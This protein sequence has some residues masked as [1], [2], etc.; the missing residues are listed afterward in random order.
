MPRM[1]FVESLQYS[2]PLGIGFVIAEAILPATGT[3]GP[4]HGFIFATV[5]F[6]TAAVVRLGV[7]V[8]RNYRAARS[9]RR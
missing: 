3:S 7:K 6:G 4:L 9:Q 1:G 8:V 5:S 2:A